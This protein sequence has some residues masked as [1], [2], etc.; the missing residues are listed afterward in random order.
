ME[1]KMDQNEDKMHQIEGKM[2]QNEGRIIFRF[3]AQKFKSEKT[4]K[5]GSEW[6]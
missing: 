5:N 3:L 6:G 2:D 4:L 1:R